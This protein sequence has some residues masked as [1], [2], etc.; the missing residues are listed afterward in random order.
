[1]ASAKG[2]NV[3]NNVPSSTKQS[4]LPPRSPFPSPVGQHYIDP[5]TIG[6]KPNTNPRSVQRHPYHSRN[7]SESFLEE[8]PSWLDD[9]LNEP[10]TPVRRGGHRRSSSDSFTF[11][12]GASIYSSDLSGSTWGGAI[13]S[14]NVRYSDLNLAGR[15][16]GRPWESPVASTGF[17]RQNNGKEKAVPRDADVVVPDSSAK[18]EREESGQEQ[19]ANGAAERKDNVHGKHTQSEADTKRAKQQYAQ[20][21]RVRKL[22][23]IAELERKVQS[24]QAEGMEVSA[25]MEFLSQQNI[26]LDLENK[27]L[28]QRLESLTQEQLIKRF[29]QEMF[30]R[31]VARLRNVYQQQQQQQIQQQ[32]QQTTGM[33]SRSNSRDLDSQF[34]SLSIKHKEPTSNS[35]REP[36]S[37]PLRI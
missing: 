10:E 36:V 3:R 28:K 29:Q 21:S 25:E 12:D 26:M 17:H 16:Q 4:F 7:A 30:E 37:G 5:G 33:H 32:Q 34:A 11:F 1:M 35:G 22:Q 31:E 2:I 6:S 24:L 9:L 18:K 20:R 27:A 19:R 13:E 15:T 14:N 23:Y 8:Q